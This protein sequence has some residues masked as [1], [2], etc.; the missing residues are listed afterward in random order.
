MRAG[1]VNP[2]TICGRPSISFFVNRL[3]EKE[4]KCTNLD[5]PGHQGGVC[6]NGPV[7]AICF[8]FS[9]LTILS[10]YYVAFGLSVILVENLHRY[11]I[12]ETYFLERALKSNGNLSQ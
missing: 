5:D 1:K 10:G 3:L 9:L 11:A 8:G 7:H 2:S 6:S 12:D 4:A